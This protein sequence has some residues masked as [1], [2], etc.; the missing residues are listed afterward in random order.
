MPRHFTLNLILSFL[1]AG[2]LPIAQAKSFPGTGAPVAASKKVAPDDDSQINPF[3]CPFLLEMARSLAHN[4]LPAGFFFKTEEKPLASGLDLRALLLYEAGI[5]QMPVRLFV[6]AKSSTDA[7]LKLALPGDSV[8]GVYSKN[9]ALAPT[10]AVPEAGSQPLPEGQS[11]PAMKSDV[12]SLS[13]DLGGMH[14]GMVPGRNKLSSPENEDSL[15]SLSD[16]GEQAEKAQSY[17]FRLWTVD[18]KSR[19]PVADYS[20]VIDKMNIADGGVYHGSFLV[21][22]PRC[23]DSIEGRTFYLKN[24]SALVSARGK[25]LAVITPLARIMLAPGSTCVVDLTIKDLLRVFVLECEGS[26]LGIDVKF[27]ADGKGEL[28]KLGSGELLMRALGKLN[29]ADKTILPA[30]AQVQDGDHTSWAK[31]KFSVRS[32][33][34]KETLL[35]ADFPG[36]TLEQKTAI[37]ELRSRLK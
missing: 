20:K 35:G 16:K 34:V 28:V 9:N 3:V 31:L 7:K 27:N 8:G 32:F 12:P 13:F 24:G 26:S 33:V 4:G 15:G 37:N 10:L 22:T 6:P 21:T 29:L 11:S 1:V 30:D 14:I 23:I 18:P 36:I 5:L 25:N 17:M 19:N 2:S